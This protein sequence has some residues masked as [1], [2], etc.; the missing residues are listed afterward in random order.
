MSDQH[1]QRTMQRRDCPTPRRAGRDR[2][3][4]A[5]TQQHAQRTKQ[6]TVGLSTLNAGRREG[7]KRPKSLSATRA[8][9]R[10]QRWRR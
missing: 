3:Q 1:P 9:V 10:R 8:S 4:R 6:T 5:G 2:Q 7:T